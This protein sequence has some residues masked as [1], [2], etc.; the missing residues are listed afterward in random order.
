MTP[1]ASARAAWPR[2]STRLP[3]NNSVAL[4]EQERTDADRHEQ[5]RQDAQRGREASDGEPV[6]HGRGDADRLLG[7]RA[8]RA[9]RPAAA[10]PLRSALR[11]PTSGTAQS[12]AYNMLPS[13][14][15][16]ASRRS[17]AA[18][19][20]SG[21][22]GELVRWNYQAENPYS[23]AYTA[24][25]P[26]GAARRLEDGQ[27]G[28]GLADK[29]RHPDQV[30]PRLH[31][32]RLR[33]PMRRVEF[34]ASPTDIIKSFLRPIELRFDKGNSRMTALGAC[35]AMAVDGPSM[36]AKEGVDG[37]STRVP[38]GRRCSCASRRPS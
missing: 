34:R 23:G 5:R 3:Q 26:R 21:T 14:R 31:Q 6:G 17:G 7:H 1:G 9:P 20:T 29:P 19:S 27:R 36:T 22:V 13:F 38:R 4:L 12:I 10:S 24:A 30:G 35:S 37:P 15:L 8:P 2:P 11:R 33:H 25:S 32:V 28:C 16:R 18:C